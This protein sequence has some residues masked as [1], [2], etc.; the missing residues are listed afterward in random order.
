MPFV[1]A[2]GCFAMGMTFE[3]A[4]VGATLNAAYALDR[5]ADVGSLEVGKQMDAVV[6]DGEAVDLIRVGAPVVRTVIKRGRVAW[7]S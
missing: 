5:H 3:E 7:S 6:V 1:L 2:L 4:L